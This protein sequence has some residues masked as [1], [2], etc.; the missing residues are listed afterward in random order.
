MK[1]YRHR[2]VGT[3]LFALDVVLRTNGDAAAPALGGSSGNVLSILGALGWTPTPVGVLG[4]DSACDRVVKDFASVGADLRFLA[5]VSGRRTPVIYQHQLGTADGPTHR[6]SFACPTCG[7]R[8]RPQWEEES[9]WHFAADLP[10]ASVFFFDRPTPLGVRLAEHYSAT[11][12]I[13]VFEPSAV[14]EDHLFA[15]AVQ[16][17]DVIKYADDRLEEACGFDVRAGAIEVQTLGADGLR[18]RIAGDGQPWM[19][20]PAYQLPFVHDTA[21]AG[22][23]CTAGMLFQ[24][25]GQRTT[26]AKQ[27]NRALIAEALTFGQALS[28]LNCMTEG[29]RGLLSIWPPEQITQCAQELSGAR[30]E[31][32]YTA[33]SNVA[34]PIKEPRLYEWADQVGGWLTSSFS[35]LDSLD[36]CASL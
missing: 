5:R 25:L 32:G 2:I 34:G 18:F 15:R 31:N 33:H 16:A 27:W 3:G 13:V 24:L 19:R 14:G 30:L 10:A 28:T 9:A 8:R 7:L 26:V 22:D 23:W 1:T 29:A 36:Y 4:D 35:R 21:G 20:L 11:G 17:C 6:F 12:A